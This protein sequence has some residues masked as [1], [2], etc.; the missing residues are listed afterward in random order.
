MASLESYIRPLAQFLHWDLRAG[1]T[2]ELVQPAGVVNYSECFRTLYLLRPQKVG[3][4]YWSLESQPKEAKE[5]A[6]LGGALGR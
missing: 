3:T 5:Y 2:S 6:C 1:V 4:R